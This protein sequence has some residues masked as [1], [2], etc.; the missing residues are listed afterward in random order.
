MAY[1]APQQSHWP[2]QG[3]V[4]PIE[5]DAHDFPPPP[6]VHRQPVQPAPSPNQYSD[7]NNYSDFSTPGVTPGAEYVG[8]RPAGGSR[9]LGV[10][11]RQP[12]D[13]P[14]SD[15]HAYDQPMPPRAMYTQRT[16][17]SGTLAPGA[18]AGMYSSNSSMHSVPMSP[19]H[20][21]PGAP[22][23]DSPY[24]RYSST[25][26]D[27]APGMG[28]INPNDLAD[29]D[30]WGM[31]P[32]SPQ[33]TQHKRRSFLPL[34]AS[35]GASR[36][37]SGNGSPASS[38]NAGVA[39][40]G[41]AA[42]VGGAYAATRDG[43]GKYNPVPTI[44]GSNSS[45][46]EL[47]TEKPNWRS[48]DDTRK[49]KKRMWIAMSIIAVILLGAI[50]GGVLG[51]ML[52]RGG[53]GG[54]KNK[55]SSASAQDVEQ[56]NKNDL[57]KD[58]PEIKA[59]LNNPNMHNVFP[60]MDYTPLN[61]QYPDCIHVKPSQNNITRDMAVMSQLTTS[62]R[63]YGTDCNQTQMLIHAIDRLEIKDT[64]KI[65]LGVWLDSNDTTTQRQIDQTWT[66]LDD[67][68][69]DYFK[70]VIIGNEVLFR[71]DMNATRLLSHVTD[72]RTNITKH[73][74][75][76]PVA[77]ADLGDNWTA[78]MAI[79]VDVVMSNVHP[80]FAG[81]EADKAAA[82]T[83]D[84]WTTHDVA[85]TASSKNIKQ[86]I[87]EVGWPSAGGKNCGQAP[88]C[89]K[90]SVAG[91]DELNKFMEDWICPRKANGTEYFW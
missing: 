37:G 32:G 50:L 25:N 54:G 77:M 79:K 46:P 27:M 33:T 22:Y 3:D 51:A 38:I 57:S 62:V 29:D 20:G 82:W 42:A 23:S 4:S 34:G 69:C 48:E 39:G 66:I 41:T 75:D 40:A 85:L 91:I 84:F 10:P 30:D 64:M 76:L 88:S 80:F 45:N 78:D 44:N 68:G 19:P 7:P 49:R 12:S 35:R 86:V 83:M 53:G 17:G 58:S 87:A 24:N 43:S 18:A 28:H 1:P 52:N 67:Y 6:P 2:L 8:A 72:F 81:V 31:G 36:E 15:Q 89:D 55:G 59:L 47:L 26:L 14:F 13:T 73:K 56:D 60:G 65:W 61:A 63:T 90:G 74:C 11:E 9:P 71:K 21:I 16:Y 70:G 5:G